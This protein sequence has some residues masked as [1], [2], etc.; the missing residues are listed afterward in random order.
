MP[1]IIMRSEE[2]REEEFDYETL[3]EAKEGFKRLKKSSNEHSADDGIE[4]ELLLVVDRYVTTVDED[5]QEEEE[6]DDEN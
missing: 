6:D 4:R 5:E 1:I 3:K 2:F